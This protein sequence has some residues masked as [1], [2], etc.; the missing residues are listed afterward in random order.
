M[1]LE[2]RL[3]WRC[4]IRYIPRLTYCSS[5]DSSCTTVNR[6]WQVWVRLI[7]IILL[8]FL[9]ITLWTLSKIGRLQKLGLLEAL[10]RW[11]E[12][13][14]GRFKLAILIHGLRNNSFLKSSDMWSLIKGC[15][16]AIDRRL[17]LLRS[18]SNKLVSCKDGGCVSTS[19]IRYFLA[20]CCGFF[21]YHTLWLVK[22][23]LSSRHGDRLIFICFLLQWWWIRLAHTIRANFYDVEVWLLVDCEWW[24]NY[25]SDT[26]LHGTFRLWQYIFWWF[27]CRCV[28]LFGC[29]RGLD[30]DVRYLIDLLITIVRSLK[31]GS[32]LDL[33][34]T[35]NQLR[36]C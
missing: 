29:D 36:L 13:C 19:D 6:V 10:S 26:L 4:R 5:L 2:R 25:L 20:A 35:R 16:V 34:V 21:N 27:I 3:L 11:I 7:Y 33:S 1:E 12:Q 15:I 9:K 31:L 23:L 22:I 32:L 14:S 28:F 8:L 18:C 17:W 24:S 30:S